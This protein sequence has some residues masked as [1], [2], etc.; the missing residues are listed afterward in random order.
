MVD[1]ALALHVVVAVAAG[2]DAPAARRWI[3]GLDI[4][5]ALRPDELVYLDDVADGIRVEDASRGT[6]A[7]ALETAISASFT[8]RDGLRATWAYRSLVARNLVLEFV[9]DAA[10]AHASS[11]AA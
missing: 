7:E 6:S 5:P 9:E 11:V 3:E 10:E 1:R 8:A 2:L 4:E